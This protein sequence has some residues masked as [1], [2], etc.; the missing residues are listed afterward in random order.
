MSITK[1]IAKLNIGDSFI[2]AEITRCDNTCL[3][4]FLSDDAKNEI[5]LITGADMSKAAY[6]E[7]I[8]SDI[9]VQCPATVENMSR[10]GE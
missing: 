7:G 1:K 3:N 5:G 4:I 2:R 8:A 10:M 6:G 9:D